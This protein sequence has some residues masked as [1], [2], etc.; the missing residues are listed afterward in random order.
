MAKPST[1]CPYWNKIILWYLL[2]KIIDT[3]TDISFWYVP[4]VIVDSNIL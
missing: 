1:H 4:E 2:A 3:I